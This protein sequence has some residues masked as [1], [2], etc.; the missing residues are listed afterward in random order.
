MVYHKLS[1]EKIESLG[2]M[3]GVDRDFYDDISFEWRLG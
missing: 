2:W 3:V 1:L